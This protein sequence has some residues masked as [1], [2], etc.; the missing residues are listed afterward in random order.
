MT[1]EPAKLGHDANRVVE[2]GD[3]HRALEADLSDVLAGDTARGKEEVGVDIETGGLFAPRLVGPRVDS[4]V[5]ARSHG[6]AVRCLRDRAR[7]S[8]RRKE[9]VIGESG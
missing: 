8:V 4:E 2:A 6:E 3:T 7:V 9:V 5:G 1:S